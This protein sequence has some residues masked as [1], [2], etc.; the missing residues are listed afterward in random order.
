MK[1]FLKTVTQEILVEIYTT[2]RATG[3][4]TSPQDGL[5]VDTHALDVKILNFRHRP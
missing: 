3:L 1:W 2:A 4:A 5:L